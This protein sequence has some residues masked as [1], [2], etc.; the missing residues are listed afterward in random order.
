MRHKVLDLRPTQ[1]ALGMREVDHRVK[2]IREF[3]KKELD[4]YL[5]ERKVP[6]VLGPKNRLL[7]VDRHHMVRACWEADVEEVIVEKMADFSHLGPAEL[8]KALH[9]A[10]WVYPY[11][12]LGNG[13][14]DPIHLPEN[15]KGL[16][17]D[18]YRSLAWAVREDGG[19][20]KCATPFSEFKW[21]NF[22]RKA[23]KKHPVEGHFHEAHQEA[24]EL[25]KT[26]HCAH[27]PGHNGGKK[28]E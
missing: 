1:M 15:I 21:A 6:V 9:E 22:F 10:H 18:P 25:A 4:D 11:D 13:P 8:W 20:E 7:I 14:H 26:A 16:A 19:F 17:D 28:K 2:K 5:G 24:L 27:L 3:S 12:Q 23:L